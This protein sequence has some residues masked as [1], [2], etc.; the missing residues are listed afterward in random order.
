M[1]N[2]FAGLPRDTELK[3]NPSLV[4][5]DEVTILG[6]F[7]FA[8]NHFH[9]AVKWLAEKKI[10]TEG[11]ITGTYPLAEAKTAFKDAAEFRGIKSIITLGNFNG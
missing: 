9:T 5:Y 1:I 8:P 10:S 4:H 6:T 7:G 11:I 3:L 2:L